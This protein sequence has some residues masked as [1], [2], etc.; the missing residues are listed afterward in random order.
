[1]SLTRIDKDR[2]GAFICIAFGATATL[3]GHGYGVGTPR[4]MGSGFFPMAIGILLILVGLAI[5]VTAQR[6]SRNLRLMHGKR[7]RGKLL[8]EWRAW[9]C[10]LGGG[11][12]FMVLG[13]WGGLVPASFA[14]VFIAAMGDR[15]NTPGKAALLAIA[16]TAFSVAVFY[17]LLTLQLP[18][19]RWG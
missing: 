17:Y 11:V 5:G 18:L 7:G 12:A 14:C 16:A 10:I 1:M 6:E 8:F 9:L 3:L 4:E 19:F 15:N 13:N 2:I